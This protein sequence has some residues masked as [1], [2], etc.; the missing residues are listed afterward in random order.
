MICNH[1][2]TIWFVSGLQT[3]FCVDFPV[4]LQKKSNNKVKYLKLLSS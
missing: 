2:R 1:L 3:V 4:V